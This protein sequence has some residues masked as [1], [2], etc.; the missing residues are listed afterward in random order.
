ML[1]IQ[2]SRERCCDARPEV[3]DA[4]TAAR[5]TILRRASQEEV[6]ILS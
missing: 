1:S 5:I 2:V 6:G 3:Q 4:A